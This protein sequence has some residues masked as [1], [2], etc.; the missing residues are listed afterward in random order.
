MHR[1]RNQGSGKCLTTDGVQDCSPTNP[2]QAWQGSY[3]WWA[4][5]SQLYNAATGLVLDVQGASYNRGAEIDV[6]YPNG[7]LNQV[8][9]MPG[10][11]QI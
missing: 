4:G 1:F 11:G 7:G 5:G 2:Y 9:S 10:S 3:I 6:W 8:F